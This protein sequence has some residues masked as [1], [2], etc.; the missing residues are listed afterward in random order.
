ML[1][2]YVRIDVFALTQDIMPNIGLQK[3]CC[4][5]FGLWAFGRWGGLFVW[6]SWGAKLFQLPLQPLTTITLHGLRNNDHSTRSTQQRSLYTIYTTVTHSLIQPL[7]T[8][9]YTTVSLQRSTTTHP[10]QQLPS[11][12][13]HS[14]IGSFS[15]I[16]SLRAGVLFVSYA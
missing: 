15:H 5:I 4:G 11:L 14:H 6:A 9:V 10:S 2:H 3:G 13:P 16:G 1:Q 7:Y 8:T 12:Q